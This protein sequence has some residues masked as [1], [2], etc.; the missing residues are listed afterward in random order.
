M[1]LRLS[2]ALWAQIGEHAAR[3]YPE[4]CCGALIGP[5]PKDFA[6]SGRSVT[7]T[8]LRSF[9]NAWEASTRKTRYQL[10]PVQLAKLER[11]FLGTGN[12]IV[13]YY[14]SHPD[15]PDWPSPFDLLRAWPCYSYLIVSVAG[16]AVGGGRS[17]VR[18]DDGREFH[19]EPL[20]ID[21][22]PI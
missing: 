18:S 11:E 13:G 17:W 15:V 4:E 12:G 16:A 22:A 20:I 1:T 21:G 2:Q 3:S 6:A 5:V 8:A 10:E 9:D 19:N 14:H 7:A